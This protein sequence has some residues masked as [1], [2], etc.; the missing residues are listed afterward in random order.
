[1]ND[2]HSLVKQCCRKHLRLPIVVNCLSEDLIT[3]L[4]RL[5]STGEWTALNIVFTKHCLGANCTA[6]LLSNICPI[7]SPSKRRLS[8]FG[9][10]RVWEHSLGLCKWAWIH[11]KR[12]RFKRWMIVRLGRERSTMEPCDLRRESLSESLP[13]YKWPLIRQACS[14]VV[15]MLVRKRSSN[16]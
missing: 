5:E 7:Q 10:H 9:E 1:M 15:F 14:Q 13:A 6:N 4:K 2:Q 8:L 16:W 12:Y 11:L 3:Y